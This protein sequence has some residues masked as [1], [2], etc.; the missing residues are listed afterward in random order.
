MLRYIC[1]VGVTFSVARV[2]KGSTLSTAGQEQLVGEMETGNWWCDKG[3]GVFGGDREGGTL[4]NQKK[5]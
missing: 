4:H 5:M 1:C 3:L 2:I